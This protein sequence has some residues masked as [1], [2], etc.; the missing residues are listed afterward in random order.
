MFASIC[1]FITIDPTASDANRK[2]LLHEELATA[3]LFYTIWQN[4]FKSLLTLLT[5]LDSWLSLES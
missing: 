5:D 4:A 1:M 2:A 3:K